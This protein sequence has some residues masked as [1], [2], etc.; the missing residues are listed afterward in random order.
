[1]DKAVIVGANYRNNKLFHYHMQELRNL[2]EACDIEV[3]YEITQTLSSITPNF[4]IGSGK[5]EEI[6]PFV[7]NLD[8]DMVIFNVELSGSQIR[9]LEKVLDIKVIDRT[10][11]IL[12]IFAKRAKTKASMLEVEIAQ[13]EYLKPRL[14]S[15]EESLNRQQG[16]IGSRGP[17][18][19]KLETDRRK[20]SLEI[21]NLKQELKHI[22]QN[23][24]IQRKSRDKSKIKKVAIVG[25]TNAGKST[26]LNALVDSHIN[27]ESKKVLEKDMLFATLDTATRHIQLEN[28]KEFIIT[29]TVGFVSNLPHH[30]VESFKSTLEEIKDT[31]LLIHVVD[32]SHIF[33]EEQMDTT[34][35]T[36]K[37]LGV[38]GINT[39]YIY[40]KQDIKTIDNGATK[41]PRVEISL[42]NP[43]HLQLVVDMIEKELFKDYETFNLL[44]PYTDG[45]V[46][47]Y[48]NEN[49]HI[50]EQSYGDT[51]TILILELSPVMAGRYRKYIIK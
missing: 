29:D 44:I 14:S 51:G 40:N 36:L 50:I 2:T 21:S 6:K 9:N 27:E 32:A 47:A 38:E 25:Y 4:Y 11:L 22:E 10:L 41:E 5:V 7:D 13:L 37:E 42:N 49:T 12:D 39:I 35:K 30:L 48:L 24:E 23:R 46:V 17:G 8:A 45:D 19:K 43:K 31:D 34:D 3:V 18:E 26:L 20:I 16:G 15:L 28:N 33:Q 1:M